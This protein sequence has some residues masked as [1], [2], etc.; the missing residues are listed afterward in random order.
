MKSATEMSVQEFAD[1]L[2]QKR[3]A[4]LNS[5]LRKDTGAKWR[6]NEWGSPTTKRTM[7]RRRT[8]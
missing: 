6:K 5:A 4:L 8:K 2:T 1:Y 3:E 7:Q